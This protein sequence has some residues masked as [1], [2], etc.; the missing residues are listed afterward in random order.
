MSM[1]IIRK[2]SKAIALSKR[3]NVCQTLWLYRTQKHDHSASLHVCNKSLFYIDKTA[4]IEM[5]PQST[6]EFNMMEDPLNYVRPS[7]MIL[8]ENSRLICKG[9]VQMFESVKIECLPGAVIEIGDKTYINHDSEIRCREHVSIGNNVSI[10]YN[11]L[12]QD[13][14]YHTTYDEKGNEKPQT[15]PIVIEDDVWIGANAI[16]LKGVTLGKGCVVAAGSVV[17]KSVPAY[18]L[19]GGNPAR[20]IKQDIKHK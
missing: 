3:V 16:I 11:V 12:I 9:H 7:R 15:L 8:K 20:V 18:A 19:V 17:T 10:A 5:R 1:S 6:L 2:I 4:R 14:D 13:S